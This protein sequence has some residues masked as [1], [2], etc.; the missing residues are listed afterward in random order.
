LS[1][2]LPTAKLRP[3]PPSKQWSFAR[4]CVAR[5]RHRGTFAFNSLEV[6]DKHAK[7]FSIGIGASVSI[8]DLSKVSHE[9][10]CF[11]FTSFDE[12]LKLFRELVRS[13]EPDQF[14]EHEYALEVNPKMRKDGVFSFTGSF[15]LSLVIENIGTNAI[16]P[17]LKVGVVAPGFLKRRIVQVGDEIKPGDSKTLSFNLPVETGAQLIDLPSCVSFKAWH[18]SDINIVGSE[19]KVALGTGTEWQLAQR[20]RNQ[21][22]SHGR[23]CGAGDRGDS[24]SGGNRSASECAVFRSRRLR[25]VLVRRI[26]PLRAWYQA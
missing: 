24:S 6:G 4:W 9:E 22:H 21:S 16:P 10:H 18:T 25:Q 7:I 2:C 3:I 15:P 11:L 13:K 20:T 17:G 5:A 19:G 26:G 8:N 12:M 23:A 14:H 1:G